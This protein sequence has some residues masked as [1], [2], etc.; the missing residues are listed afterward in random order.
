M[1]RFEV[2]IA[3]RAMAEIQ[4]ISRAWA[5]HRAASPKLFER[6]LDAI[7]DLLESQPEIGMLRRL[8]SVGEV[9]VVVLRRSRYLVAY[10]VRSAEQQVW[11][12]LVR[13]ASRRPVLR[14]I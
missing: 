2:R 12:V 1:A 6:E 10:Q 4:K 5:K 9:R 14:P 3:S 8:R 7:L 11:I 13:H